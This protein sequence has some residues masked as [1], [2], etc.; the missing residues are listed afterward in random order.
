[1]IRQTA[2]EALEKGLCL[3]LHYN[4]YTRLVEVHT[5]GT[6]ALDHHIVSVWQVSG[7]SES[8]ERVGWKLLV[9]DEATGAALT[10]IK[11]QAPRH[12]YKRGAKQ[13]T[14]ILCQI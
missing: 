5:V 4:G 8:N 3:T 11:S 9:L 6:N 1:M 10:D 2:R 14:R 7:G 13:F 12:G